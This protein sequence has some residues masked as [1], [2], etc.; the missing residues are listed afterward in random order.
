M[1][2]GDAIKALGLR[3]GFNFSSLSLTHQAWQCLEMVWGCSR[4]LSSLSLSL[5]LSL[6]LGWLVFAH[7]SGSKWWGEKL[8]EPK[9]NKTK[10]PQ[11]PPKSHCAYTFLRSLPPPDTAGEKC[12]PGLPSEKKQKIPDILHISWGLFFFTGQKTRLPACPGENQT[13]GNPSKHAR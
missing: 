8:V 5:F 6:G 2:Q 1:P 7:I 9:Q 3:V 10:Q 11:R 13:P 4:V 12:L